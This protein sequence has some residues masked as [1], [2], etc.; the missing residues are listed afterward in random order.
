MAISNMVQV[1]VMTT[2][3]EIAQTLLSQSPVGFLSGTADEGMSKSLMC[4]THAA[5]KP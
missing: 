3:F 1:L 2:S 4:A 5:D